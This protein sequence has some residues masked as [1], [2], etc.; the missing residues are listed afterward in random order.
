MENWQKQIERYEARVDQLSEPLDQLPRELIRLPSAPLNYK[1]SEHG[2]LYYQICMLVGGTCSSAYELCGS[3]GALWHSGRFLG[4][5][6][7]ARLLLEFWGSSEYLQRQVLQKLDRTGDI[8][9][10]GQKL[11]KLL[12]GS[13]SS[14][15]FPWGHM[16]EEKPI[17]VMDFVREAETAHP[18]T[19][20][21]YEFLCDASHPS[22]VQ[23]TYLFM[24]GA[25]AVGKNL[26]MDSWSNSLFAPHA[27]GIFDRTLSAA[28]SATQGIG[29]SGI[30]I[31]QSSLPIVLAD[32]ESS[33]D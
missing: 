3:L 26:T 13:K 7:C 19:M 2:L 17:N 11:Q 1:P 9:A 4:A 24:A 10:A 33:K 14:V 31:L 15:R 23:H 12:L 16:S 5:S 27:H 28:E 6:L 8:G 21:N 22:F 30:K 32:S 29:A 20:A 25:S 18:G